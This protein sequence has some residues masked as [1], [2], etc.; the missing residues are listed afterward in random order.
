MN[1]DSKDIAVSVIVATYNQE[2]T[3]GR[4]LDS[5]LAQE[6]RFPFEIVIGEDCS[7]DATLDI[8]RRYAE[9]YPD[10]IRLKAN[11]LNKGLRDNYYD[12][13]L[14]CRGHYVADCA[15]DDYWIDRRKLQ[16]QFDLLEA[17]PEVT[18]VH[19][20]WEYV[21]S[22]TGRTSPSNPDGAKD[23][24]RKP[25]IP[26]R[27]MLVDLLRH[28]AAPIVHL[29][30]AMYRKA[31][32]EEAYNADI[33]PYRHKAFTCEDLQLIAALAYSG[34]IAFLPDVTLRYTVS[35][36]SISGTRNP[37]KTFDFFSGTFE[38][39]AYL[40]EKY[41]VS[42]ESLKDYASTTMQF[43]MAQAFNSVDS[44]RRERFI[45]MATRTGYPLSPKCRAMLLLSSW[46]P[47]WRLS[48]GLN[49]RKPTA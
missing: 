9:R 22:D 11:P 10:I 29:C 12:C 7:T 24:Y 28:E 35:T 27:D 25:F 39:T 26:G 16:K 48:A 34:D 47:I 6:C 36:R 15:G 33:Y 40:A 43:I 18:L 41:G 38:L 17:H 31:A 44:D 1:F 8:C 19:T 4:T 13:L 37:A 2:D 5:I 14:D 30:T 3:I 23:R 32:V 42:K 46:R 20:D 21:D 45:D 49:S